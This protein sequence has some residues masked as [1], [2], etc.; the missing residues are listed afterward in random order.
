MSTRAIG[1]PSMESRRAGTRRTDGPRGG[2]VAPVAVS[3]TSATHALA[4][5]RRTQPLTGELRFPGLWIALHQILEELAS[6]LVPAQLLGAQRPFPQAGRHLVALWKARLEQ[7]V[8]GGR[9]VE[10]GL[11]EE[12]F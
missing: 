5:T 10:L 11:G 1:R 7:R 9:A 3:A 2:Y 6:V 12:A 8:L 4:A